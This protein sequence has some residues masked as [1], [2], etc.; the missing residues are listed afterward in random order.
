MAPNP[1]AAETPAPPEDPPG[2]ASGCQGFQV[3]PCNGLT[4]VRR[5]ENSGVLVRPTMMAPAL[6][7]LRTSGESA[8]AIR[9][10]KAGTPLV[11]A[12]PSWSMF[13]LVVMGTP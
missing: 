10:A 8:G 3:R 7:R 4:V 1:T 11:V 2:D 9:L 13:S 12:C 5:M 6:R